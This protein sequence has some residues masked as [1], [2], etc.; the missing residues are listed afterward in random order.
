MRHIDPPLPFDLRLAGFNRGVDRRRKRRSGRKCSRAALEEVRKLEGE[1]TNFDSSG[2]PA[3]K[4]N[5]LRDKMP[6]SAV[7]EISNMTIKLVA[8]KRIQRYESFSVV[9]RTHSGPI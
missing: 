8:F 2:V 5:I 7:K 3:S 9:N 4:L 6:K 1:R